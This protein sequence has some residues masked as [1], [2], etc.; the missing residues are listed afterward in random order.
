MTPS[1]ALATSI[2]PALEMLGEKFM[3]PRAE[4]MLLTI[5]Q[6]ESGLRAIQQASGG[7]GRGLWQF[8]PPA[9]GDVLTRPTSRFHA[10]LACENCG[11]V[12]PSQ[13]AVYAALLTNDV[14]AAAFARLKLWNDPAQLPL[15]GDPVGAWDFYVQTWHPGKPRR[16]SWPI[17]YK[18]ST[19]TVQ[20]SIHG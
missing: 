16:D 4:V 18:I 1:D 17:F 15:V 7:P 3:G 8:E 10:A 9:C 19:D 6:Q 5:A 12:D 20:G 2:T 13:D 14:L 11:G